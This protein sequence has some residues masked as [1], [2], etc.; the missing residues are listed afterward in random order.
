MISGTSQLNIAANR[1]AS[2]YQI[3]GSKLSNN[4][5]KISSGSKVPEPKYNIADYFR[6]KEFKSNINV[7]RNIQSDIGGALGMM[8]VA[9][10][11]ATYVFD[12]LTEMKR[13]VARY[14]DPETAAND[15]ASIEAVFNVLGSRVNE[16]INDTYYNDKQL[17]SDT[18][19]AGTPLVSFMLNPKDITQ[20][21]EIDF[22]SN[23]VADTSALDIT[24]GEAAAT[25]AVQAELD[26]A[27]SYLGKASGYRAGLNAQYNLVENTVTNSEDAVSN[28]TEVDD[29]KEFAESVKRSISQQSSMA[30][31]AQANVMK[32]SILSLFM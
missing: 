17:I 9:E 28:M 20:K 16:T 21:F 23:N 10:R 14:Y 8:D 7:Y 27:G 24:I 1:I 4:L 12:D 15:K 32:Q 5:V 18:V 26:K 3:N 22:D 31:L 11:A 25:A 19:G 2:F 29:A 6:A 13:L 30:M